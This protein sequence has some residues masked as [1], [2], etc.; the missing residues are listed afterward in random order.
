MKQ[1]ITMND[2]KFIPKPLRLITPT[3]NYRVDEKN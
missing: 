3:P 2:Y 1:A